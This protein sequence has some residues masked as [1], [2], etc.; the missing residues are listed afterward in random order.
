M[1]PGRREPA[2]G[3]ELFSATDL[4]I[5]RRIRYDDRAVPSEKEVPTLKNKLMTRMSV[6]AAPLGLCI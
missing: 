5:R 4:V 6:C 1:A 3:T 2:H